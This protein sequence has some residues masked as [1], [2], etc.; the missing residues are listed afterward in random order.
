MKSIQ[1]VILDHIINIE[2]NNL[3]VIKYTSKYVIESKCNKCGYTLIDN[4]RNLSYRNLQCKYCE[5]LSRSELVKNGDVKIEKI[6][7]TYIYLICKNSHRYKQDR[8][9]LLA[10]KYCQ[11]CYLNNKVIP[12]EVVIKKFKEIHGDYYQYSFDEFKNLHSLVNIICPKGHKFTQNIS[13]HLQGKA[14]PICRESIGER[15][16][17][18]Y[19]SS[20]N[21]NFIR[22]KKFKDCIYKTQLPFDFFLPELN[23]AIEYDGLQHFQPLVFFGGEE[24][25]K[26]LQIKDKIKTNYC[27]NNNIKLIR[28]SHKENIFDKLTD[29]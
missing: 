12:K 9:N 3:K 22:Q 19:L 28:I 4:Y 21:L 29:L 7:G 16:I 1:K 23:I 5:L 11:K 27:L 14:C 20:K 2:R 24:E 26:K 8:R 18:L 15:T 25:F 6:E 13:N 10:G 17:S